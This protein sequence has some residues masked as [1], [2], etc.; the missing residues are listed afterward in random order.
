[1]VRHVCLFRVCVGASV[2]SGYG[3]VATLI[4]GYTN[5]NTLPGRKCVHRSKRLGLGGITGDR[6][7]GEERAYVCRAAER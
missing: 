3:A 1:M 5:K 2:V 7:M 6:M 4:G